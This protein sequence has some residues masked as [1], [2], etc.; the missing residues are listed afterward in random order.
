MALSA[1]RSSAHGAKERQHGRLSDGCGV[2]EESEGGSLD[3]EDDSNNMN[4]DNWT[5]VE[6][7]SQKRKERGSDSEEFAGGEEG[8][9]E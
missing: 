7:M 1:S 9:K 5:Q 4:S 2:N 8:K 3:E 6:Q